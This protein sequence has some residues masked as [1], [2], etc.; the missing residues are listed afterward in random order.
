M[1]KS[2]E[3]LYQ[4]RVKRIMDACTGKVP[5]RVPIMGPYEL[6]VYNY[7]GVTIK[8]A[9]NDYALARR[10]CHKF[11]DDFQPDADFGPVL[12]YPA[13][14]MEFL[15]VKWFKWAG[16]GLGDNIMY[17]F[18]EGEYM[19][20][21][22]YDEFIYD[23]S[24]FMA[25]KWLPRSF[26]ALE[27]FAGFPP[28]RL[29]MWFGWTG[30]L[31]AFANP[32]VQQALQ[33]AIKAGKQLSKWF[34]SLGRYTQEIKQKGFPL[35]YGA[36]SWPPFDIIGDTLRGTRGIMSDMIRR[37]DKL[38]KAL[39]IATQLCIEYG[40]A[41]A[42]ADLPLTWIWMHKGSE[43]FMS[44]EQYATFYWPFLKRAIEGLVERGC[45]VVIYCEGNDTPR[46]KYF[47]DVPKGK[48]VYH[49]AT[50]DMAKA[51]E[52]LHGIAAI[53]GNVPN[54]LLLTG[55]PDDVKAYCKWLI[56]TVGKDGGYIMDTSALLDEAKPENVKAMFEFTREYGVYR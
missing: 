2:P 50:M 13:K 17:Q 56:D 35:A 36:L 31:T 22:E 25:T 7:A 11:L 8:E 40:S 30:L 3:E 42:G 14:P 44:D 54:R 5:D 53:S 32:E 28:M 34:A 46:L 12:A 19:K 27:G 33:N 24:H 52:M 39:E 51:K 9:M 10:A 29:M 47:V 23:P 38:L 37:P 55:T 1:E 16:H 15:G 43:G 20:A 4:E 6:F 41:A 48:V 49:F 21:E 45:I 26:K 18:I